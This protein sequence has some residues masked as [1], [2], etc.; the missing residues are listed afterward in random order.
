MQ[1][2]VEASQKFRQQRREFLKELAQFR[3]TSK[4]DD[5]HEK[6]ANHLIS[7]VQNGFSFTFFGNR[8]RS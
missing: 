1:T 8:L 5:K 6:F 4:P 3:K 7:D 2:F